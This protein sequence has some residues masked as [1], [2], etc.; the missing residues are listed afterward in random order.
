[1]RWMNRENSK[2]GRE[3][4]QWWNENENAAGHVRIGPQARHDDGDTLPDSKF[5]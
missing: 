2:T 5:A 1:M 3:G 4:L